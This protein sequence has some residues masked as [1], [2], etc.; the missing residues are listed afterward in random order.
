MN[1][2]SKVLEDAVNQFEKLP[3]IGKRTA[4]RLVLNLLRME[5]EEII[6]FGNA[7]IKLSSE[8]KFCR[9]CNNLSDKEICT[10]CSNP[11]RDSTIV[12]V[13]EDLRDIIA[14]ENTGQYNGLYHSL[15]GIISPMD[16]IGPD[17]LNIENLIKRVVEDDVKEIIFALCATIE[18][19]TTAFYIFKKLK[20]CN[21]TISSIARGISIGGEL[22]NADEITLGRSIVS[23]LPYESSLSKR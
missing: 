2:S 9:K 18:G 21:V 23:R 11:H 13:V 22:E 1:L 10:I 17:E 15:G 7:F 20:D 19:D 3:G 14:I 12:C 4:I 8:I 16:G 5:K 6:R